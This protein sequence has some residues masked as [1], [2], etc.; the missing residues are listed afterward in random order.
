MK[1][2]V[3]PNLTKQ[4]AQACTQEV[5]KVLEECG[6]ETV[7]KTDLF[8]EHGLYR[9]GGAAEDVLRECDLFVAIGG[10]GTI[11]HT[12][13]WPPFWTSPSWA[14]NAGTLGFTAGVE[15]QEL[16]RL[17]LLAKGDFREEP[18]ADALRGGKGGKTVPAIFTPSTTRCSP[19]S[20]PR[21]SITICALGRRSYRYRPTAL[22]WPR[23]QAPP[24]TPFP[25]GGR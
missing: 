21:S 25:Q 16:G 6:C 11:I 22:S 15:R 10:D 13:N 3:L 14:S 23:P 8:S 19:G 1:I 5:L 20:P 12:P 18:P 9:Q 4:E 24:P 2:A 7:L 17:S